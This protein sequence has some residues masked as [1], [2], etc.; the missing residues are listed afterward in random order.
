MTTIA[1]LEMELIGLLTGYHMS[2][3]IVPPDILR[4]LSRLE[5]IIPVLLNP[6][7]NAVCRNGN[8]CKSRL[9]GGRDKCRLHDPD[10]VVRTGTF[11]TESGCGS[12]VKKY[13]PLCF[14]HAKRSGLIPEPTL[15]GECSIC[16]SDMTDSND[17]TLECGHVFHKKCIGTWFGQKVEKTCPMCRA[18]A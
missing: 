5:V 8:L 1:E 2:G 9:V 15:T 6:T 7:C 13:A 3:G 18:P 17:R 11:C 14:S 4:E 10:G 16:Y 12:F